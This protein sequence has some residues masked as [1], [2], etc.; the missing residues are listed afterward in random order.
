MGER[1][2]GRG[3]VTRALTPLLA[4][5]AIVATGCDLNAPS[6]RPSAPASEAATSTGAS[7]PPQAPDHPIGIRGSGPAAEFFDRRTR[8]KFA[9][10][11]ANYHH[12][13]VG[14]DGLV[15]DRTFTPA[16]YDGTAAAVDLAAMRDLGYTV[17]RT[18][19]DICQDDCIGDPAGGLSQR[20]L[21]NVA[22]FLGRAK[23]VGLPVLLESNDLPK[24]G[25]F[26]PRV[27]ATCCS[28][29]DGYMNSQYFAPEG[30]A[31]YRDYWTRIV[32]G[33]RNAGAPLDAILAYGIRGEL[34]YFA[35]KPP[36]SLRSGSVTT[37]NG[38][39]YDMAKAADRS[40]LVTDGVRFWIS[41]MRAAVHSVDPGALVGVGVFAPN[42]PNAWRPPNDTRTVPSLAVFAGAPID[43]FD[44]HPYP[45][46]ISL[47]A[48][49]KNFGITGR[50]RFPVVI[51]EYGAFKFAFRSPAAG[52]RA[53]MDWQV[54]SCR[55]GI[56]GWF[57]WHFRG[58]NDQ[59]VWTGT[60]ANGAINLVLSPAQR[61]DPCRAK[62]FAFFEDD[63]T[64]GATVRASS[65]TAADRPTKAVDGIPD[66]SWIAGG[67]P[68]RWIELRLRKSSTLKTV[69][70]T[71]AQDPAGVTTH[72]VLVGSS[73]ANLHA[74]HTF[75]GQTRDGQVLAW[76][77][78]A[79]LR[80]VLIVRILTTRSPSW[81]AWR[82]IGLIG[83][84]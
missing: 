50:E 66:T 7:P 25:G 28:Q 62:S 22:D 34:W 14:T 82:E 12:L 52:A 67:G 54:A 44:I 39:T 33:L 65:S 55:F 40:R 10:R 9:V 76:T 78:S 16:A 71:V 8:K 80:G 21:A 1:E 45:G 46:Y 60:E 37:A 4:A 3:R 61:P 18:A 36:V 11:G 79:P 43:F 69:R 81:V 5:A 58:T 26:V 38:R 73:V 83:S 6:A 31:T 29:F 20:Y 30:L 32:T 19:V 15:S 41:E 13:E 68:P 57:H 75:K 23:Q 74:V 63:L 47:A 35:D 64:R 84:D 59:E 51:G 24:R 49:M 27:E 70:L 17:V 72:V 2:R 53:L 48:L 56:D 77:P 42:A